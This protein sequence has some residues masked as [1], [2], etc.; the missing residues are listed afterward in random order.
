[1]SDLTQQMPSRHEPEPPWN[2]S[3]F[4]DYH[5]ANV[6][7]NLRPSEVGDACKRFI[8][9]FDKI[10][11]RQ[12]I[13][14]GWA[15]DNIVSAMLGMLAVFEG[16]GESFQ[17]S[18]FL[19][20]PIL[21][22]H[23]LPNGR[24]YSL[25]REDPQGHDIQVLIQD[26]REA[27]GFPPFPRFRAGRDWYPYRMQTNKSN[28]ALSNEYWDLLFN[29]ALELFF[30]WDKI[31]TI[32]VPTL[33]KAQT[34][35]TSNASMG[36]ST[37]T[38]TASV[39]VWGQTNGG[40]IATTAAHAVSG[41][42]SV[43]LNGQSCPVKQIDFICDTALIDVSGASSPGNVTPVTPLIG[44]SPMGGASH[45]F[46]G[47]MTNG[48]RDIVCGWDACIPFLPHAFPVQAHVY[49]GCCTKP[50]DSGAALLD[51]FDRV[52]GFAHFSVPAAPTLFAHTSNY[53]GLSAW[54][55][56]DSVFSALAIT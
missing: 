31:P 11:E 51:Q 54:V 23:G 45:R 13:G 50:G 2:L 25:I 49:T 26:L 8:E 29:A 3:N 17:S 22:V 36:V 14:G 10:L 48:G 43:T 39:G 19:R 16:Y 6:E 28:P 12:S 20:S 30:A 4:A 21:V 32:S 46:E 1:L 7:S 56:A 37:G 53:P 52:V 34:A 55:W 42:G 15:E 24:R 18:V 9:H 40:P 5:L 41:I 35:S 44:L 33:P 27:F 47:V 38:L